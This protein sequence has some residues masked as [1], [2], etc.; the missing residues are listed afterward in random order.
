MS[1]RQPNLQEQNDLSGIQRRKTRLLWLMWASTQRMGKY[2]RVSSKLFTRRAA[3]LIVEACFSAMT[4]D[5]HGKRAAVNLSM[6]AVALKLSRFAWILKV[7]LVWLYS[8]LEQFISIFRWGFSSP[9][10]VATGRLACSEISLSIN[11]KNLADRAPSFN[12]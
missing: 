9:L 8:K 5:R 12:Q 1:Q 4:R 11:E 6:I 2:I 7:M 3:D 10:S